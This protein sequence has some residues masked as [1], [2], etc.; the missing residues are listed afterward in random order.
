[1]IIAVK[2]LNQDAEDLY[3]E[4]DLLGQTYEAGFKKILEKAIQK[5]LVKNG[6]Q[7]AVM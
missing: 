1:M 6:H 3:S 7:L 2:C 4:L 5:G